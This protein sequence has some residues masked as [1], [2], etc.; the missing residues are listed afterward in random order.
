MNKCKS[1]LLTA[2]L[3]FAITFT[4]SCTSDDPDDNPGSGSGI[5]VSTNAN[6]DQT[7]IVEGE[8]VYAEVTVPP[9]PYTGSA[10]VIVDKY[11][12][13]A[14]RI[15]N[16][17]LSLNLPSIS[18][19]SADEGSDDNRL[20]LSA[21]GC[22]LGLL[23]TIKGVA[24]MTRETYR[25]DMKSVGFFFYASETGEVSAP[26]GTKFNLKKGWNLFYLLVADRSVS[27]VQP[28]GLTWEWMRDCD[29]D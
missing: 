7:Y 28:S 24:S 27:A 21:D 13:P 9:P 10:N 2:S 12:I 8:Q 18:N 6:G 19:F 17:K 23:G 22:E 29:D 3:V 16:G 11:N 4:L 26:D 25:D 5:V 1:V 15:E 20:G 14:G